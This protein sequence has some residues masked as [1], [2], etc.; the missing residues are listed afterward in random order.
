MSDNKKIEEYTLSGEELVSKVKEIVKKGH[1]KKIAVRGKDGTEMMSF[2]VTIG[3]AG[4]VL[5]PI[6]A[7]LG[8]IAALA[9]KCTIVVEK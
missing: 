7:A 2:P 1:A 9:T 3:L 8:T 6:F 4:V 5:A